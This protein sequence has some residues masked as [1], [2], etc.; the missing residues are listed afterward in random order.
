L[1]VSARTVLTLALT[2]LVALP[3]CRRASNRESEEEPPVPVIAE[4]ARLGTIRGMVSAT[5]V[6]TT[7]PGATFAVVAPQPGRIAEI[8]KNVGDPVK[9]GDLLVRFEFPSLGA[10]SSVNNALVKSAELRV[11]QARLA[12]SRITTLIS[13]GAAA[14]SE[15]EDADRELAA[16]EGELAAART[17]AAATEAQGQHTSIHAPFDG[18]VAERLHNPGDAVRAEEGDPILRLIDPKQVQVTA[19][20][21]VNAASRFT[22]GTTAQAVAEGPA[23][24]GAAPRSGAGGSAPALLRVASRPAP[25]TGAKTVEIALAFDSPTDLQPGTQVAVEIAAEQHLNVVLVPATAV[26]RDEPDHPF[27]VVAAGNVAQRRPVVIGLVEAENIEILSGLKSGELIITQGQS[28]LRDGTPIT[29][30]AP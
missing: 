22:V 1:P 12:Q 26:V 13:K 7:L 18:T 21:P 27:V 30:G 29:I 10:Q 8:T 28:T 5:G 25:E 14:R 2:G 17:A 24:R 4:A 6:V 9:S 19:I 3:A 23:L 11:Q 15:L 20:I 16:A